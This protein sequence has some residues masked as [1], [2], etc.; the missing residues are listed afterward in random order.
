MYFD[1]YGMFLAVQWPLPTYTAKCILWFLRTKSSLAKWEIVV[2]ALYYNSLFLPVSRAVSCKSR[3]TVSSA[4]G[5]QS[6]ILTEYLLLIQRNPRGFLVFVP[7]K[8]DATRLFTLHLVCLDASLG[9]TKVQ[10]QQ[11][12]RRIKLRGKL[13]RKH[14]VIIRPFITAGISGKSAGVI[15]TPQD[16]VTASWTSNQSANTNVIIYTSCDVWKPHLIRC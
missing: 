3:R 13:R 7:R 12:R 1:S 11:Q 9:W 5:S 16:V 10:Q 14:C 15:K 6:K 2:F 4:Q 8:P